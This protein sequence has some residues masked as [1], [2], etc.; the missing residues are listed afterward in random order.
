M[1]RNIKINLFLIMNPSYD[2]IIRTNKFKKKSNNF[3]LGQN[4]LII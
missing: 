4:K 2:L 3:L 1:V